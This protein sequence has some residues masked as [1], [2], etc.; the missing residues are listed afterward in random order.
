MGEKVTQHTASREC[1]QD[2]KLGPSVWVDDFFLLVPWVT[3]YNRED[4]S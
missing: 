1:G 3:L 2:P 4:A